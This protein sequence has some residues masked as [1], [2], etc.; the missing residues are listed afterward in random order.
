MS[1]EYRRILVTEVAAWEAL[2]WQLVEHADGVPCV[3][4]HGGLSAACL[5]WRLA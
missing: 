4:V 1:R 3:P 5:V 2:G